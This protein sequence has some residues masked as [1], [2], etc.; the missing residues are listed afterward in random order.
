MYLTQLDSIYELQNIS[1]GDFSKINFDFSVTPRFEKQGN[2]EIPISMQLFYNNELLK[3]I[4]LGLK[5][6]KR[7][8]SVS[9]VNISKRYK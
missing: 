7:N 5:L 6:K 3:T 2:S 4:D 9:S 1:S 8:N